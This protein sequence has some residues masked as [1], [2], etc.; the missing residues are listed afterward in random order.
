MVKGDVDWLVSDGETNL[1]APVADPEWYGI[2]MAQ[3]GLSE[4]PR[5]CRRPVCKSYAAI[6]S[7]LRA[8]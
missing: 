2:Q 6:S 1:G 5:I 7:V 8:A 3:R 4:P